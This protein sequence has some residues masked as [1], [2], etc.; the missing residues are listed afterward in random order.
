M[1]VT[2]E[3]GRGN[4][5]TATRY[6]DSVTADF[7]DPAGITA[8]LVVR[9]PGRFS[10]SGAPG[11]R[12]LLDNGVPVASEI[13]ENSGTVGGALFPVAAPTGLTAT[14]TPA[15]QTAIAALVAN[16]GGGTLQFAEG[17]YQVDGNA[18]LV[19][20]CSDFTVSGAGQGTRLAIA[21]PRPGSSATANAA[22]GNV[23]TIADC[24]DFAVQRLT[25]DGRR[26]TVTPLTRL[27]A[28]AVTGQ[29]S[30]T[31]AAG[32][33]AAY[34]VGQS[35][36]VFGGLTANGG[37]EAD[38]SDI[39]LVVQS[40]T[41]GG[42]GGG[43]DLITF[44]TNL[45]HNYTSAAGAALSDG[46]G[47]YAFGGA[48]L[49]A[50]SVSGGPVATVA[51]RL[52]SGED[53][54][55][56]LHLLS[57]SRF[58][59]TRLRVRNLWSSPIRLGAFSAP[60]QLTDGCTE[61]SIA[62]NICT[63]CYD[64][65]IA[66]WISTLVTVV[67]NS[68]D[69]CGWAGCSLTMSDD[70]VVS[71]NVIKGSVYRVPG[72]HGSGCGIAI[73]GGARNI[74]QGNICS[75][76]YSRIVNLAQSP[77]NYGLGVGTGN[78][79]AALTAAQSPTLTMLN[80]VGSFAVGGLYSIY[81]GPRTERIQVTAIN[82]VTKVLTLAAPTRF[83]HA[84]SAFVSVA[85]NEENQI[86]GNNFSNNSGNGDG[87][88]I[89][90]GMRNTIANNV[91]KGTYSF[92]VENSD[93]LAATPTIPPYG[94]TIDSNIFGSPGSG[95]NGVAVMLKTGFATVTK[96]KFYGSS[97]TGVSAQMQIL[98]VNEVTVAS[99]DFIES[100]NVGLQ[101]QNNGAAIPTRV[102]V[103]DNKFI[104]CGDAGCQAL[105][106]NQLVI[107]NNE[108]Y[109]CLGG[110][111]GMDLRDVSDSVILG[112]VCISNSNAGIFLA[113]WTF[114]TGCQRCII[115]K[116]ICKDD[117]TGVN[118]TTLAAQTQ[119]HGIYLYQHTN[120]CLVTE[121]LCSGNAQTQI[122]VNPTSLVAFDANV[123]RNNPGVNP[124]GVLVLPL[125]AVQGSTP[126]VPVSGTVYPN[127]SHYDVTVAVSGGTVSQIALG[128][129][130][131]GLTSGA[132]RLAP[133]QTITITF[134]VA[135]TWVWIA[136]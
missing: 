33:G 88:L 78:T 14:D 114:G 129:T 7:S 100:G 16:G 62:N 53:Q 107:A 13:G 45:A 59:V 38:V 120:N 22:S 119:Q 110:N 127:R 27:A 44:T 134:S 96:N 30:V 103:F 56:G 93:G 5:T 61:A 85:N 81:D 128:G 80:A 21:P 54:A 115:S 118:P 89:Q 86:I 69:A 135:P 52:L 73:E 112:N 48:Y 63:H 101:L 41:P 8:D 18:L 1:R 31:V 82:A 94:T 92:C 55:N 133:G 60:T 24:S 34:V 109:S 49:T 12:R 91:F 77:I 97:V 66:V 125:A 75:G 126:A 29:P 74:I 32:S 95:V 39:A 117:G 68:M 122:N 121:N 124:A 35:L 10:V 90:C 42:G 26:D 19:R 2:Y 17:V 111:G 99:N 3:P 25:I 105:S 58:S 15:V 23:L 136:E 87:V 47:P 108:V 40:I 20:N 104:R 102:K 116:N 43:G 131:T 28:N 76:T 46:Y 71:A 130:N 123:V 79:L 67:A 65:G 11:S 98:G 113:D 6:P 37:T 50:Y 64:Q 36:S 72:D 83:V 84:A 106:G 4:V 51:G 9:S 57:C 132:F 70:C